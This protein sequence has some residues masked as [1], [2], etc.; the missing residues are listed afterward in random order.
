MLK[1]L[2][3]TEGTLLMHESAIGLSREEIVTQSK[4]ETDSSLTEWTNYVPIGNSAKK[5]QVWKENGHEIFY[6]TSRTATTEINA[7]RG[8][9]SKHEFPEA[10]LLFR[11]PGEDY[12]DIAERV[13]PDLLI[14]DDCESI[15]GTQ[16]MTFTYI[17]TEI[18]RRIRLITV[19]EFE[20]I[21]HLPDDLTKLL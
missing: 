14:E 11:K 6:L 19:K 13:V 16:E 2:V 8:V 15:G 7:I 12:K 4:Y 20:G 9:L 1:I 10:P 18:Q 5:I 21:D 17:R 3:F